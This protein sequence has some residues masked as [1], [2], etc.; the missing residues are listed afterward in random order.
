VSLP[1]IAATPALARIQPSNDSAT[2]GGGDAGSCEGRPPAARDVD[3]VQAI[4]PASSICDLEPQLFGRP[5]KGEVQEVPT[6][7]DE[8]TVGVGDHDRT[9]GRGVVAEADR[10]DLRAVAGRFPTPS[11]LDS[12]CRD[13]GPFRCVLPPGP[14]LGLAIGRASRTAAPPWFPAHRRVL[15][16]PY[17]HGAVVL[18]IRH[19]DSLSCLRHDAGPPGICLRC[20]HNQRSDARQADR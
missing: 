11:R 15:A 19:E 16:A 3:D 1:M 20:R 4:D 6:L 10:G 13:D 7:S 8:Y 5:G 17:A 14:R 12:G 9:P 18:A 2:L